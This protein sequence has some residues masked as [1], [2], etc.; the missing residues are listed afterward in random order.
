MNSFKIYT[1]DEFNERLKLLNRKWKIEN[2][3]KRMKKN[4]K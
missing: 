2:I 1:E 3:K 4:E